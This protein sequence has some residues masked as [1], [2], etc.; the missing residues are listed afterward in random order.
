[1]AMTISG[2]A[3]SGAGDEGT[4]QQEVDAEFGP[5]TESQVAAFEREIQTQYEQLRL[6]YG[7]YD[8]LRQADA[9]GG[10]RE[11]AAP[12]HQRL[13]RRHRQLARLHEERLWLY[14]GAG[15]G[16]DQSLAKT[17]RRAARWHEK[18]TSRNV[19]A[20]A[21]QDDDLANLR[22]DLRRNETVQVDRHQR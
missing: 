5:L 11:Q 1:M 3:L 22:Q 20:V 21:P 10:Q 12:I 17:H 8:R 6:T 19:Q 2:C 7:D 13:M 18:Q 16:D 4:V 9:T 15:P 14:Q